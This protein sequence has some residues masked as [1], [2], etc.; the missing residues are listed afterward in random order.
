MFP[1]I[2]A[3]DDPQWPIDAFLVVVLKGS[4]QSEQNA[5]RKA[6]DAAAAARGEPPRE[7]RKCG[8]RKAAPKK[9]APKKAI[10][11]PAGDVSMHSVGHSKS[12]YMRP[13]FRYF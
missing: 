7:K 10:E 4:S 6:R 5:I 8:A 3:F 13:H 1:E 2:N 12:V 9:A 11:A